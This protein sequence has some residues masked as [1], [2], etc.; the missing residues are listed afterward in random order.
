MGQVI[1]TFK[2]MPKG[3]EAF[4]SLKKKVEALKPSKIEEEP[5]AF[6]LKSIKATFVIEDAG[7]TFEKLE[8]D[9]ENIGAESVENTMTT[10]SL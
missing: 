8:S 1:C 6:G 7:G 4:D 10:R 2:L 5:I 3:P 9:L